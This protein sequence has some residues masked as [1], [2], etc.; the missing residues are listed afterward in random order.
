MPSFLLPSWALQS[1]QWTVLLKSLKTPYLAALVTLSVPSKR[2]KH[3]SYFFGRV[4]DNAA[5]ADPD[6][7]KCIPDHCLCDG[8]T[9]PLL[10]PTGTVS[11]INC[12]YFTQP[13]SNIDLGTISGCVTKPTSLPAAVVTTSLPTAHPSHAAEASQSVAA[14]LGSAMV[15][16]G[17]N[18]TKVSEIP[19]GATVVTET[20]SDKPLI[21]TYV[22]SLPHP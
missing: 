16:P 18:P 22:V 10:A 20:V 2:K 7:G 15:V 5:R 12:A 8:I 14:A 4:P 19:T 11:T 1:K 21:V 17:L 13:A 3:R 6:K 9:V